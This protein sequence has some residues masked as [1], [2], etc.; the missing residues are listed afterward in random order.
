[1]RSDKEE[2]ASE[3]QR[4]M[5]QY[6]VIARRTAAPHVDTGWLFCVVVVVVVV[7]KTQFG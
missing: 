5:L 7:V 6:N 1:L 2:V 4:L 3:S